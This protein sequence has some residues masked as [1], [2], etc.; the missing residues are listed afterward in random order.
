MPSRERRIAGQ[1][2]WLLVATSLV[3]GS[4]CGSSGSSGSSGATSDA[5]DGGATT[6]AG[7]HDGQAPDGGSAW[8][9][10]TCLTSPTTFEL[11]V[12]GRFCNAG[13]SCEG[14]LLLSVIAP[15][16][17][18]LGLGNPCAATGS[19]QQPL[20]IASPAIST[21][22][23]SFVATCTPQP[24]HACALAGRYV[25]RMCAWRDTADAGATCSPSGTSTPV[26]VD[27]PFDWPTTATLRGAIGP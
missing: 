12:V 25:A 27:V 13:P 4:G 11:D 8:G 20:L 10:G 19:C 1:S 21:W 18:A 15:D 17:T 24:V 26:C 23:G 6:D 2:A 14:T 9:G 3:L 22:D 7:A 16:T 5:G